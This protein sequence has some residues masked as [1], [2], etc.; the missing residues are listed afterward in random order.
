MIFSKEKQKKLKKIL[1][2]TKKYS[3]KTGEKIKKYG[4]PILKYGSNLE[5]N[6]GSVVGINNYNLPEGYELKKSP[7]IKRDKFGRNYIYY[8][9]KIVK[10]GR[11]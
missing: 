1:G 6:L 8:E 10:K 7:K 2:T 3:K 11:K 9:Y 5:K 4:V